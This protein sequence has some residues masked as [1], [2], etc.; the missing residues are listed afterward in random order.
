MSRFLK[1]QQGILGLGPGEYQR[2]CS[3]YIVKK[4]GYRNM[5]DIGSKEGTSKTTRGIP[6]SYNVNEDGTYSLIMYGTVEKQSIQKIEKDIKDA[7][8]KNKTGISPDKIKEI[9][10]FHTNTNIKP[11]DY[12]RLKNL[13]NI[14]IELIDIDS[15][16]HDICENYQSLANEYFQIPIDTNQI[17]DI[18]DFIKRY[19]KF[20]INSPLSLKYIERKEKNEII[21]IIKNL[22]ILLLITG[23]PGVGKTKFAVEICKY[24]QC[25][26]D[27]CCLCIR[28]NGNDIYD[29]IKFS[30]ESNKDYLIFIDDINNLHQLQSLIDYIITQKN[31]NIK[32]VATIRDYLLNDILK[33]LNNYKINSNVYTLH[34]M[35]DEDIIKILESSFNIKNEQWQQQILKVSNGNPR[36]A[37]MASKALLSGKLKYLNSI[38]DVFKNYYDNIIE[39]NKLSNNQI[40]MLFYISIFSPFS[41]KNDQIKK[42]LEKFEIYD[43]DEYKKLRDLELIEFYNDEVIKIDDQNF[44]N[45]IVYK[46]L[47]EKKEIKIS[48]LLM[49][50]YPNFIKKFISIINMVN[51]VFYSSEEY[52]Y[53]KDEINFVWNK[54]EHKEEELFLKSFHNVNIPKTL[55]II[56]NKIEKEKQTNIPLE[57]EYKNNIYI[58]NEMLEILSD[59]K[60]SEYFEMA[61][62]LLIL[63]LL[64]RPDLYN[65]ICKTIK[66]SWLMKGENID[67]EVETKVISILFEEY[68]KKNEY[69]NI[70]K[71]IITESL[72]YCLETEFHI[73]KQ[74]KDLKTI[75]F[76]RIKLF[77]SE[78]LFEFR[79][80]LFDI[81]INIYTNDKNYIDLLTDYSIWP[82]DD[83]QIDIVKK[84]INTLE[85][86]L[87]SNWHNPNISQCKVLNFIENICKER[88]IPIT[89]SIYNYR[90]NKEYEILR[91]FEPFNYD[92]ENTELKNL[93]AN[94]LL[95]DYRFY[96]KTLKR[97]ENEKIKVDSWK[98][99]NSISSLFKYVINN[100]PDI[101]EKIF[102]YY[103]KSDCPFYRGYPDYV[104]LISDKNKIINILIKSTSNAKYFLLNYL[105]SSII[106]K[107]YLDIVKNFI[108]QQLNIKNKYTMNILTIEKYSEFDSTLIE[109]YT[110]DIIETDDDNLIIMYMSCLINNFDDAQKI[111]NLFVNKNILEQLY[112]KSANSNDDINGYIGYLLVKNNYSFFEKILE[113]AN[114]N[115][116]IKINKIVENIW[117]DENSYNLVLNI[118]NEMFNSKVMYLSYLFKYLNNDIKEIQNKWIKKYIYDNKND[119]EKIRNI[120]RLICERDEESREE[121]IMYLIE[122]SDDINIF[123]SIYLFSRMESWSRSRI[124]LIE[125]KIKFLKKIKMRIEAKKDIHY[126]LHIEYLNELIKSE[127]DKIKETKIKEYID[128]FYN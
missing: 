6:D 9:I 84:D 121:L 105:L 25:K 103:L 101:F 61:F 70:Y 86:N 16:A 64:K 5:L 8:S 93:L 72:K 69:N 89:K 95:K 94:S 118:Y 31:K 24:L 110:R 67:F 85:Q 100:K 65:E 18:D 96:F 79:K 28:P 52:E 98:I 14:N 125:N 60:N 91:V 19:D 49:N 32:I 97:I 116:N 123:K 58:D 50:L 20:S 12:E 54:D 57:L 82:Y 34:Q 10:C 114:I 45:Y 23:K 26:E 120:F 75:N 21:N 41:I 55:S 53:I 108:K 90:Q 73:S 35:E 27:V 124:P 40:K 107:K 30:L 109:D 33:K 43:I 29:D 68:N 80:F 71:I 83:E 117:R 4:K 2:F 62:R 37:V 87:F 102:V 88:N 56:K 77:P 128:D 46:Y 99:Q 76:V 11:G 38:L 122:V 92:K 44:S 42:I 112:L 66:D 13:Y 1:V 22:E 15:M 36:I 39:E 113:N 78:K 106:D 74:G 51:E 59:I 47:I 119:K 111:Y 81:F 17:S 104:F 3:D 63:Y 127:E 48:S 115:Y 126:I 7:Y